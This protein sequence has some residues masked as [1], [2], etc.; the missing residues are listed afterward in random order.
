MTLRITQYDEPILRKKGKKITDFDDSL[1]NLVKKMVN[2]MNEAEGIGIAAQQ[3]GQDIQLCIV[4]ISEC[5]RD[6]DYLLDARTP[7]L[8]L[9]MPM[10]VVNPEVEVLEGDST[11][12]EEGCL[13]FPEIRGDVKRPST[14]RLRFQDIDGKPHVLECDG[15][16]ARCIQHEV[17]HLNGIL[18][19]DRMSK[20]SV[21]KLEPLLKALQEK[22]AATLG[23]PNTAPGSI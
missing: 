8:E 4:D 11:T 19:I 3:I 18:F 20:K 1:R 14:V 9:I 10:T 17:D 5:D 22:T 16:F 2:T 12:Y 21:R 13:S 6:F 15:I 23:S 7:P